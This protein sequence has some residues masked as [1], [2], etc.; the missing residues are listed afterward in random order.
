[1]S[2][3]QRRRGKQEQDAPNPDMDS[4]FWTQTNYSSDA[5]PGTFPYREPR[6]V[7]TRQARIVRET[8]EAS[9]PARPAGP[10]KEFKRAHT[11]PAAL[12]LR[13][14]QVAPE[15]PPLPKGAVGGRFSATTRFTQV[16]LP[17]VVGGRFDI[18]RRGARLQ[19]VCSQRWVPMPPSP[20]NNHFRSP[21]SPNEPSFNVTTGLFP[22]TWD[23]ASLPLRDTVHSYNQ[24]TPKYMLVGQQMAPKSRRDMQLEELLQYDQLG[25]SPAPALYFGR[26]FSSEPRSVRIRKL[27]KDTAEARE[28]ASRHSPEGEH[29]SPPDVIVPEVERVN[30]PMETLSRGSS[31][32]PLSPFAVVPCVVDEGEAAPPEAPPESE[33]PA[34]IKED[35]EVAEQH[36]AAITGW[37]GTALDPSATL[38][39]DPEVPEEA[40]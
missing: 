20:A 5:R 24:R 23:G 28:L 40:S 2:D 17:T 21:T 10:S 6:R 14:G 15:A 29:T 7:P 36:E 30:T 8:R 19:P 12:S 22:Q 31:L 27:Q 26:G 18:S 25:L 33:P 4:I 34:E 32:E 1:M 38:E 9:L 13:T 16:R 39:P 3:W 35:D 11:M 37:E